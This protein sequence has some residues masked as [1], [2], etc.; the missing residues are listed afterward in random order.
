MTQDEAVLAAALLKIGVLVMSLGTHAILLQGICFGVENKI[1]LHWG[2][3]TPSLP[4][5]SW[6]VKGNIAFYLYVLSNSF[7][8]VCWL[9]L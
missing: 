8:L 7:W 2:Q 5:A 3:I 9:S 6:V 4:E 1:K